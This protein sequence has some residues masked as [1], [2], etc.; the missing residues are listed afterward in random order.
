[1][2][3]ATNHDRGLVKEGQIHGFK[4][5]HDRTLPMDHAPWLFTMDRSVPL[6][7]YN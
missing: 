3:P 4:L 7:P 6:G 5:R 1:V 2:R